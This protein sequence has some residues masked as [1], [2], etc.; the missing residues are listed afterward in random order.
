MQNVIIVIFKDENTCYRV[1][2]D[3]KTRLGR[4]VAL[5]AGIIKNAGGSIVI[6]DGYRWN[7][8]IGS[9]WI[10]GGLIGGLIGI[11]AGPLGML[12]GASI[13]MLIGGVA[14]WGS[15]EEDTVKNIGIIQEMVNNLHENQLA[16]VVVADE[17]NEQELNDFF[18]S[19]GAA[20]ILRRSVASVQAEVYQAQETEK[21][22]RKQARARMREEKKS[23]WHKKA[24]EVQEEVRQTA[25]G[26]RNVK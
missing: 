26:I 12:L 25:D 17:E 19:Y 21:E 16:L 24:K 11:L 1:L 22:L 23:E 5:E 9:A 7:T 13:G 18:R 3:L 2:S 4:S 8:D 20:S 6:K 15:Y 14:D 10:S